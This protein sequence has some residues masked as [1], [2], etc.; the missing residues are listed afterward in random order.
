[1]QRSHAFA[2][3]RRCPNLKA[4]LEGWIEAQKEYAAQLEHE[5]VAWHYQE[6]SCVGFLAAGAWRSHGI[7]LEE[8]HTRKGPR[9]KPW[10]GRCDLWILRDKEEFFVEAKHCWVNARRKNWEPLLK[11]ELNNA[12]HAAS[13]NSCKRGHRKLGILFVVPCYDA[14]ERSNAGEHL[15]EW[16]DD[17][18]KKIPHDAIAW[19]R[20]SNKTLAHSR[21]LRANPGVLLLA[22][23]AKPRRS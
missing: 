18:R 12:A 16:L 10:N 8:W 23:A 21:A 20:L 5:D 13:H 11:A 22:R 9:L 2:E 3:A 7:A 14:G 15:T 19:L 1:M 6:R 17:V 4:I